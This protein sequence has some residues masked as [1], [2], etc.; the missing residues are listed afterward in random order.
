MELKEA[1]KC[2]ASGDQDALD[3]YQHLFPEP[4]NPNMPFAAFQQVVLKNM[5][6]TATEKELTTIEEFVETQYEQKMNEVECTWNAL[7]VNK[8]QSEV[9]LER[10]YVG[11]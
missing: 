3:A 11:E 1:W 9:D 6:A 8:T 4:H 7:K 2:Y 10:Q 5:D